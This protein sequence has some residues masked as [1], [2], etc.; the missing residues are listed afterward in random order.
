M[1]IA[2]DLDGV[3]VPDC[4]RIPNLGGL[5]EFYELTTYMRPLFT[6]KGNY[7]II[8]ARPAEFRSIT[9]EWC[10]T[11]LDNRPVK[12]FHEVVDETPAEYKA[13]ILNTYTSIQTYVESDA[14][15]VE[16]LKQLVTTGCN[17][18]HFSEFVNNQLTA[19]QNNV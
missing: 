16:E 15:I 1:K 12:L 10:R 18:I 6:P 13:Q 11:F 9:E 7:A 2:F 19:V 3:L 8:T 4:D 5:A 14:G 17:I